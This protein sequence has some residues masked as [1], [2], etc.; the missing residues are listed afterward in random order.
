MSSDG[1]KFLECIE[2]AMRSRG[3]TA[4]VALTVLIDALLEWGGQQVYIPLRSPYIAQAVVSDF[5]GS[6]AGKLATQYRIS[7]A[8]VYR[9][10]EQ[11]RAAKRGE[12]A[13][14][15]KQA[16]LPGV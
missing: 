7:R 8:Q 3:I 2:N 4:E 16:R 13:E 12:R 1:Q 6:N 5:D 11:A 10:I 14:Q 9:L 15:A